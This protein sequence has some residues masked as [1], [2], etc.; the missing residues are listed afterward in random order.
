[1]EQRREEVFSQEY[2]AFVETLTRKLNEEL[3]ESISFI[4]DENVATS[5]FLEIFNE[6][7][8]F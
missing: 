4:H 7:F 1:M 3:W 8:E 6:S 2:D 5:D